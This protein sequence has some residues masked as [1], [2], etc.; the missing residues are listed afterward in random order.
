[1]V[2]HYYV[3]FVFTTINKEKPQKNQ[4]LLSIPKLI[5]TIYNRLVLKTNKLFQKLSIEKQ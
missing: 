1:M 4:H 3:C 5:Y 2:L